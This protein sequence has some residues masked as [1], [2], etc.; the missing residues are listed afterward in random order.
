VDDRCCG[1]GRGLRRVGQLWLDLRRGSVSRPPL[2]IPRGCRGGPSRDGGG[3]SP[4][5]G[6]RRQPQHIHHFEPRSRRGGGP[7]AH[8]RVRRRLRP[9]R[10]VR[11]R[12]PGPRARDHQRRRRAGVV[13]QL[14][15]VARVRQSAVGHRPAARHGRDG[16][17]QQPATGS[18]R[19]GWRGRPGSGGE[20]VAPGRTAGRGRRVRRGRH[21]AGA[22]DDPGQRPLRADLVHSATTRLPGQIPGQ[23]LRGH[24]IWRQGDIIRRSRHIS[25]S[26]GDAIR[27]YS[28]TIQS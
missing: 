19:P 6:S 16:E 7:L 17:R 26:K 10:Y 14:V 21:R 23:R 1:A 5:C 3:I 12:P 8:G 25:S 2:G 22:G 4:I 11:R 20:H 9:P 13:Q 24:R 18:R 28:I 15:H 27:S